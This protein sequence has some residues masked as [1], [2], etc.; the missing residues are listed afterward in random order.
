MPYIAG[1][2]IGGTF[3]DCVVVDET[4]KIHTGKSPTTPDDRSEGFLNSLASAAERA[5]ITLEQLLAG[6]ERVLH[7]TTVAVNA[8]VERKGAKV[9]LITTRG[10]GDVM[11]MMRGNGRTAGLP[12][13][14]MLNVA[15]SSKPVPLV[16]RTLIR[17]VDERINYAGEEVVALDEAQVREAVTALLKDDVESICVSYLWS[18]KNINHELRTIEIIKEMAPD[19]FTT[20]ASELIPKWGEYERTVGAV[21]NS[22]VGPVTRR[23]LTA[24]EK[25]LSDNNYHKS[26]MIMQ[27]TG[28]LAPVEE[29]ATAPLLT[30]GSGPVGGLEGARFLAAEMN[31]PNIITADMGGTTFDVGLIVDGQTVKSSSSII[32]QY[33]YSLPVVDVQS[34]GSGG[35]SIAWFD[36]MSGVMRVGPESAGSMPGPAC[37]GR[38]G[39]EATITDANVV[40]GYVNPGHFLGGKL[41][42]DRD[43]AHRVVGEV[44]ERLNMSEHQAAAGIVTIAEFHMADLIRRMSVQRGLDPRDYVLLAYGGAGPLHAVTIARELGISKVIVPLGDVA[45]AWSALGVATADVLRVFERSQIM[46]EPFNGPEFSD[47]FGVLEAQAR[48]Y[49]TAQGFD[50]QHTE[51]RRFV[52][53]QYGWQVHQV[54]IPVRT[55]TFSDADMDGLIGDFEAQYERMYGKGAGFRQA[56]VQIINL[57]LEP[58]GLTPKPVLNTIEAGSVSGDQA[59]EMRDVY[60]PELKESRPTAIYLGTDLVD[61]QQLV[62]P[63]IVEQDFTTVVIHPGDSAVIDRYGNI[64]IN[65]AL[66]KVG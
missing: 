41:T 44:S 26:F 30:V 65:V 9:G 52:A 39:T 11:L 42:L 16:P 53:M 56:G 48:T 7:G 27:S 51:L 12:I 36:E 50:E 62:G 63:A 61:G 21:I 20:R 59:K 2:D 46:Y 38:G 54:E 22:Y 57:R 5:G 43:A 64:V 24:T 4:G 33:Q 47:G 66:E 18:F 29:C 10:H 23:Y 60:W 32:G 19:L 35:G 6:T 55:G 1:I 25:R 34:I 28:G 17:E 13:E 49:L 40:L 15:D 14:T 3:T 31:I 58:V 45:G 37:Y 8:M